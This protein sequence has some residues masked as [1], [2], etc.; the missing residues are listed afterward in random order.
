MTKTDMEDKITE[1]EDELS[2]L[3]EAFNILL[4]QHKY[5]VKAMGCEDDKKVLDAVYKIL[6]TIHD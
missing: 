5:N 2:D 4:K 3:R 6:G 1:L